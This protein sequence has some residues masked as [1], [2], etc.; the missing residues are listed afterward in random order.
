MDTRQAAA[1]P[2]GVSV[3]SLSTLMVPVIGVFS[4]MLVLG[5]RPGWNDYA[6]LLLVCAALVIVLLPA[7]NQNRPA[8]T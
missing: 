5:E 2:L 1:R 8:L 3:S 7:R 4:G 6:A